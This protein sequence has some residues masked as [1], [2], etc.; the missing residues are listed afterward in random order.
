MIAIHLN[1]DNALVSLFIRKNLQQTY[2]NL[3]EL[4]IMKSP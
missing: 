3:H 2:F 4:V 1:L